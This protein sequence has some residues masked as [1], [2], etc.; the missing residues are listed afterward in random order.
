MFGKSVCGVGPL[1]W[2]SQPS[3][4]SFSWVPAVAPG[5]AHSVPAAAEPADFRMNMS[6]MACSAR[7]RRSRENKKHIHVEWEMDKKGGRG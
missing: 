2:G 6:S 7:G 4:Q 5:I 3:P 1:P